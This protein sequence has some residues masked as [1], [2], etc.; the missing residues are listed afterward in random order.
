MVGRN[1]KDDE[2]PS[3]TQQRNMIDK[4]IETFLEKGGVINKVRHGMTANEYNIT[5]KLD[6]D[7]KVKKG[8]K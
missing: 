2:Q 7:G 5:D 8:G 3:K 1:Y 6:K 4:A